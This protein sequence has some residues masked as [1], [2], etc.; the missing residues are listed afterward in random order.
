[1]HKIHVVYLSTTICESSTPCS[2]NVL[3]CTNQLATKDIFINQ[4]KHIYIQTMIPSLVSLID[5]PLVSISGEL[6]GLM[7]KNCPGIH[8]RDN[9]KY[10]VYTEGYE[11]SLIPY[12]LIHGFLSGN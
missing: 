1:M 2:R 5:T 12:S 8:L 9:D 11:L 4:N 7:N 3:S 10:A 6:A